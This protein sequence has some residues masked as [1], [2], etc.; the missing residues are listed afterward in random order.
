MSTAALRQTRGWVATAAGLAQVAAV[1]AG[2]LP[3]WALPVTVVL[4]MALARQGG[5][6]SEQRARITRGVAVTVVGTFAL[7]VAFRAAALGPT[8]ANPL[9]TMRSLTEALVV[10]SLL[11]A[12]TWRSTR[13][14][15][16]WLSV[17]TGVLIA[18]AVGSHSATTDAL[19][20]AAWILVL[21]AM[22]SIQQAALLE[23]VTANASKTMSGAR[24]PGRLSGVMP[25]IASLIAGA[26]VFLALP[27][28]LGGGG[29]APRLVH[30]SGD[31]PQGQQSSRSTV[32]VDTVGAGM[33]SLLVRGALPDTP[34]IRVPADSPPLWRGSI[35]ATYTGNT[36]VADTNQ[37][38][39]YSP[40]N[41]VVV[42]T[43]AIDPPAV[44]QTQEDHV[45]FA[46]GLHASLLWAP[47]VPLRVAGDGGDL[48]GIITSPA[49]VHISSSQ[50]VTGYTVTSDV[51]TTSPSRLTASKGA[52]DSVGPE[53]TQLPNGLPSDISQ[54]AHQITAGAT[55]EYQKVTELETYLRSHETYSLNSPVPGP[56]QDA[57]AD[58][59]FRD[60]TGFCE[61]FASAETVMLRTLHVPARLI[62]GLAYGTP[63]GSTRLL[64]AADAHAWVEVYYPG[65]GWSP[66]DPTAGTTLAV[67][68]PSSTSSVRAVL[69]RLSTDLPGGRLSLL[70]L[71]LLVIVVTTVILRATRSWTRP[72]R[73][74]PPPGPPS[75]PVL[76]AFHRFDARR[77]APIPRAPAETARE[78]VGRVA[79]PGRLDAAVATLEQECYGTSAPDQ[80]DVAHA[81]AAF[82][83]E[84]LT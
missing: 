83:A 20:A 24:K 74:R 46:P 64:T 23:S 26:L 4:T 42:P 57:V 15:R 76:S 17:T 21:L 50:Q 63:Q 19:L 6:V 14:Y 49:N 67:S 37:P 78:Y 62:S 71:L 81:V 18:A 38:Y 1:R 48:H 55:T 60:H 8:E 31:N 28:G 59:L 9:S 36:W 84:A 56:G 54:L 16:I 75:R 11:M 12:P 32:G 53:W 82:D 79:F 40:G 61:Q 72:S 7:F 33:L 27:G 34:L 10:L 29:F 3:W 80:R 22:A 47:G 35:Y 25:V 70:V 51:A 41:N 65:I 68:A 66:T 77:P 69:H 43:R 2:M 73:D 5:P 44:G 52:L 58:F 45:E 13:E 39:G 30:P